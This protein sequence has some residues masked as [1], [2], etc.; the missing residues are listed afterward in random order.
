[1]VKP[2]DVTLPT[3]VLTNA[4]RLGG[5]GYALVQRRGKATSLVECGSRS[6]TES[7]A[8]W[9]TIELKMLAIT[10]AIT[11]KLP[12]YLRGAPNFTVTIDHW[13]LVGVFEKPMA[14]ILNPRLLQMR[15]ALQA[16]IFDTR[17]VEGKA[18]MVADALSRAPVASPK[19]SDTVEQSIGVIV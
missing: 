11:R 12:Y 19:E 5:L 7:E 10:W 9:S 15:E 3:E 2:F 13:P 1:V 17:W 16:Y 18:H 6:L 4:S 8:N 14:S